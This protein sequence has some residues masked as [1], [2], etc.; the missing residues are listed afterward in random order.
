MGGSEF[1]AAA[2]VVFLLILIMDGLVVLTAESKSKI[3]VPE[4]ATSTPMLSFSTEIPEPLPQPM[5]RVHGPP[6]RPAEPI[7]VY[8]GIAFVQVC[9]NHNLSSF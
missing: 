2:A 7:I 4:N 3:A 6:Q 9:I 8:I 5:A 1:A